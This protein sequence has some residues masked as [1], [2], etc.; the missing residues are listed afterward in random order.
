M[1]LL[2]HATYRH[3]I[4]IPVLAKETE[5]LSAYNA[6][7]NKQIYRFRTW[8]FLMV[9][10]FPCPRHCCVLNA[11]ITVRFFRYI[12]IAYSLYKQAYKTDLARKRVHYE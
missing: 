7:P 9:I 8:S 2:Y 11:R 3:T 6:L 1:M 10:L 12:A 5:L 4:F